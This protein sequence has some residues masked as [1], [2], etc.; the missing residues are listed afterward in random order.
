MNAFIYFFL[1]YKHLA[2]LPRLCYETFPGL[3]KA[4]SFLVPVNKVPQK[5]PKHKQTN[6]QNPNNNSKNPIL[7]STNIN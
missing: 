1:I 7:A 2:T 3:H 6:K 5:N 4:P